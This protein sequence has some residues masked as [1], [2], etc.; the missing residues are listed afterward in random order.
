MTRKK[1]I[2]LILFIII[3]TSAKIYLNQKESANSNTMTKLSSSPTSTDI[4]KYKKIIYYMPTFRN[5]LGRNDV[6]LK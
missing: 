6:K 4:S 1:V 3:F 5:G 2:I